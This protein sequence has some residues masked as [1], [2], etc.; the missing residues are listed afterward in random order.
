[1]LFREQVV[2]SQQERL[3]G[4][5]LIY[6]SFSQVS[7]SLFIALWVLL[8]CGWLFFGT[9]TRKEIVT[10]WIEPESGVAKVYADDDGGTVTEIFIGAGDYVEKGETLFYIKKRRGLVGGRSLDQEILGEYLAQKSMLKSQQKRLDK[11]S[12][13]KIEDL[14]QQISVARANLELIH[15]QIRT[16]DSRYNLAI[17]RENSFAVMREKGFISDNDYNSIIEQK[18]SSLSEKQSL[19]R[20]LTEYEDRINQLTAQLALLPS[21]REDSIAK[22]ESGLSEIAQKIVTLSSQSDLVVRAPRSGVISSVQAKAGQ[23]VSSSLPLLTI[24]PKNSKFQAKLLIPVRAAGFLS[25]G[26]KLAIRY[27]AFPYQKFGIYGGEI[28]DISTAVLLPNE[29]DGSPIKITEPSYLVNAV[30]YEADV[31]AYGRSIPVKAGLTFSADVSLSNRTL[32]EWLLEPVLSL[33]GRI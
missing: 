21:E 28:S 1:M 16:A 5:V 23:K 19:E 25:V 4:D 20:V 26:Q 18:L 12:K 6:P 14:K 8:A 33:R 7:I 22:L 31:E 27:D 13:L 24:V 3:H 2:K 15:Q 11:S 32:I 29:V 30:I 17:K 10:G 9:Y